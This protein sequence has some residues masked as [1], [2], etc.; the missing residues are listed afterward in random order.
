MSSSVRSRIVAYSLS[1]RSAPGKPAT[2]LLEHQ[3]DQRVTDEEQRGGSGDER[4]SDDR[5]RRAGQH[6]RDLALAGPADEDDAQHGQQDRDDLAGE[7]REDAVGVELFGT[8]CWGRAV[9]YEHHLFT[10]PVQLCRDGDQTV[11]RAP[12]ICPGLKRYP[13][14]CAGHAV[15]PTLTVRIAFTCR[16]YVAGTYP[17]RSAQSDH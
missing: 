4:E 16:A 17:T 6:S 9:L 14:V 7:E 13:G 5:D 10:S 15:M 12:L 2:G 8:R 11:P 3:P 1:R